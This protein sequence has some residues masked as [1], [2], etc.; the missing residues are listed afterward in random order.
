MRQ[1]QQNEAPYEKSWRA[2]FYCGTFPTRKATLV[3]SVAK[4][5]TLGAVL[6]NH[7]FRKPFATIRV[8]AA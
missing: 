6:N 4:V 8:F 1:I 7:G 5:Y 2:S 3:E